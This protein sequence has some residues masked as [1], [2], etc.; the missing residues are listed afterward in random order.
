VCKRE[1]TD[2]R[3]S[4]TSFPISWGGSPQ[5]SGSNPSGSGHYAALKKG[6]KFK[7]LEKNYDGGGKSSNWK[8]NLLKK[9]KEEG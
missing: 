4:K 7:G 8:G 3:L 2:F 9:K 5:E 6:W 1:L